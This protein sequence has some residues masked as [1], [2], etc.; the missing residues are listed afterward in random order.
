MAQNFY[1]LLEWP[2]FFA[3]NFNILSRVTV[4]SAK[5]FFDPERYL[6]SYYLSLTGL[7][8]NIFALMLK[9]SRHNRFLI[10][11]LHFTRRSSLRI[12]LPTC[13][14]PVKCKLTVSTRSSKLDSRVSNVETF[15]FRDARIEDRESSIE[16]Q[17][18]RNTEF[19]NMQTRKDIRENDLFL[20]G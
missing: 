6:L 19:S 10:E 20:E 12:Y 9:V 15:V 11:Y 17:E 1:Q 2:K 7:D 3:L 18:S 5:F 13:T 4:N 16:F 8:I 14:V